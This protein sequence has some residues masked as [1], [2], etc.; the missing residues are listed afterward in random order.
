[1]EQQ[2]DASAL[3]RRKFLR[4]AGLSGTALF[5][6]F[7]FPAAAKAG[8]VTSETALNN[9]EFEIEMNAWILI[10]TSGR[11]T[12]V[13][14]RAEM[15]QGSFQSVPQII[16]E[17]LEVELSNINVIFA[18]GHQKKYGS[19]ITGGSST[20]RGSYINLLTLGASARILL[21]QAAAAKWNVP[22]A[23]CYAK[24]ATVFHKQTNRSF[25][26][27]ELVVDAS[28]LEAPKNVKLKPRSEYTLIG[29]P[30]HRRDTPMKTNGSAVFGLD[31]RI[32]GMVF[33]AVERNPRMR[34]K[35]KSYDD[36][37]ALKV[38]GV[39][40]VITIKMA[41][42]G[43]YRDGVAVIA[44]STWSAMRGRKALKVEW[45]DSG[46]EHMDT[47][48]IYKEQETLLKSKEG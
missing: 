29:K 30:L 4:T 24:N 47:E 7:Y 1:M 34:G 27:G 11:V 14:H 46:F 18:K 16:S 22:V 17:E 28:K 43:T 6:G 41:V 25:H 33:A 21:I 5:L 31:K 37:A 26:Y 19:Q 13:D 39:K 3:S 2:T 10:D 48:D 42:F 23:E 36:S 44:D 15:G 35:L 20:I 32:P 40:K 9:V 8:Q 38:P 12:L 45:D